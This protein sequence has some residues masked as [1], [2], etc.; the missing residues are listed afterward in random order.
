M[1]N[2]IDNNIR[3]HHF[4]LIPHIKDPDC[5]KSLQYLNFL[6]NQHQHWNV[7]AVIIFFKFLDIVDNIFRHLKTFFIQHIKVL[8]YCKLLLQSCVRGRKFYILFIDIQDSILLLHYTVLY[9]Y[10]ANQDYLELLQ[11]SN[12]LL[13]I[14][15]FLFLDSPNSIFQLL[16]IFVIQQIKVRD[17]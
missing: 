1:L 3:L 4:D 5:C 10:R 16:Q 9:L 12:A 6:H 14:F 17:L 13:A 11:C 7:T 2:I 8:N 15:S